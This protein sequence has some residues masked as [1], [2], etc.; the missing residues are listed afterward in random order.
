M[1]A[2]KQAPHCSK[3]CFSCR[4]R[5]CT[6][7]G[8]HY[9]SICSKLTELDLDAHQ[10]SQHIPT[11]DGKTYN[12]TKP[13]NAQL[14]SKASTLTATPA[15]NLSGPVVELLPTLSLYADSNKIILLQMAVTEVDN[16]R[17]PPCT[18][19]VGIVL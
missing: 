11:G 9:S 4:N 15:V 8:C 17:D 1:K 13:V 3:R 10:P 14:N 2:R 18:L 16:P 19:N 5:C 12:V 7:K 6:I